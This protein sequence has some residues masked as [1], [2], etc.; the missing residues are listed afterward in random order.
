MADGGCIQVHPPSKIRCP[1][2]SMRVRP[3]AATTGPRCLPRQRVGTEPAEDQVS[4]QQPK[5]CRKHVAEHLEQPTRNRRRTGAEGSLDDLSAVEAE[6]AVP[7]ESVADAAPGDGLPDGETSAAVGLIGLAGLSDDGSVSSTMPVSPVHSSVGRKAESLKP[8]VRKRGPVQF[9]R[10]TPGGRSGKL[11]LSLFLTSVG[12]P[13]TILPCF[14][15]SAACCILAVMAT[16]DS[17][18]TADQ[19]F[20]KPELG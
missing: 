12:G 11:D 10:S 18:T 9:V 17:L 20:H 19:L 15:G 7:A 5:G 4:Q 1:M 14:P 16:M 6:E 8:Q 13:V 2:S 3:P